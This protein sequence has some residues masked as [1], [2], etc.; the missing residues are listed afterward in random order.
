M[1]TRRFVLSLYKNLVREGNKLEAY[2]F[3]NY[4]VRRVRDSFRENKNLSDDHSVQLA[5]LEGRKNLE[6]LRRQAIIGHLYRAD[7]LII[8]KT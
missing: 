2:N 5:I 7:K 1:S 6:M 8:E 4:A 3:R